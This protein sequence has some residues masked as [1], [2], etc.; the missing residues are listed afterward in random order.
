M[1]KGVPPSE[2]HLLV[3]GSPPQGD[4]WLRPFPG[5]AQLHRHIE[6]LDGAVREGLRGMG[7]SHA[8][9]L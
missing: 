4:L 2:G 5:S 1:Q 8:R 3:C 9:L 7:R 6:R